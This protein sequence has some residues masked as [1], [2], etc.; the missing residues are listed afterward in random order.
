MT[1]D[2]RPATIDERMNSEFSDPRLVAIYDTVCP[3]AGYEAFYVSLASRLGAG[4]IIDIGCGT[5]L[6]T[7]ELSRHGHS[8]IG[9]EPAPAMLD[10][11]RLRT[12][13]SPV[14]WIAGLT[15]QLGDERADLAIMTGH[16]AQ[17]FLDDDTWR[18]ALASIYR[19]LKPGGHLAFESRNPRATGWTVSGMETHA[20]P[21]ARD[22]KRTFVDPIAGPVEVW[23]EISAAHFNQ[24]R[25]VGH[26]RFVRS[27]DELISGCDLVFRSRDDLGRSLTT[28]GFTVEDVFGD[29]DGQPVGPDSPELIFLARR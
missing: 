2:E 20:G 3:I 13:P 19:A 14:R 8:L 16:V 25:F 5:G 11:A 22:S 15:N 26:Y 10:R 9:L 12:Y 23:T 17:F 4:V 1:N 29:W 21:A 24:V 27:G 7:L 6:L 28:T 18:A